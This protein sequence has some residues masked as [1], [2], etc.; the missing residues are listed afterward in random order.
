VDVHV[1]HAGEDEPT[2]G[3]NDLGCVR[4]K[5]SMGQSLNITIVDNNVPLEEAVRGVYF[6][7]PDDEIN[8]Q[9]CSPIH[10]A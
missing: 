7:V 9:N 10:P 8:R 6:T 4:Q 5:G 1:D 3:I 2:C